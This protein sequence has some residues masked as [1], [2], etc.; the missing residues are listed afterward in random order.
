MSRRAQRW[1]VPR[2][3]PPTLPQNLARPGP[4]AQQSLHY[5]INSR[6]PQKAA[7]IGWLSDQRG[8]R[9]PFGVCVCAATPVKRRGARVCATYW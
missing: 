6:S 2:T 5:R 7:M 1:P 3:S 4:P 9:L 8:G